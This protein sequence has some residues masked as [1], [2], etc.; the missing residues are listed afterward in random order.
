MSYIYANR[1][2]AQ[3]TIKIMYYIIVVYK[4]RK[5]KGQKERE[6]LRNLKN[7]KRKMFFAKVYH[8]AG[9]EVSPTN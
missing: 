1:I 8:F 2:L 6:G 3:A 4:E 9:I 5:H 7:P